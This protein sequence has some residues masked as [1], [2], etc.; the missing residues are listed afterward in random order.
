MPDDFEQLKKLVDSIHPLSPN[1]WQNFSG[2][3][4]PFFAK[5]KEII[6]VSGEKEKYLYLVID[7]VQR[8]YYF[9]DQNRE[10]TILFTYAP[11]F[12]GVLDSLMLQQPSKYFY[13][14]LTPSSFLRVSFVDLQNLMLASADTERM[15]RIGITAALSGVLERLVELQCFSSEE[16]FRKLLRRSPHIL[17]LVPHKYLANYLGIDPTNFSKLINKIRI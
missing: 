16:K 2:A 3:W 1:D 7:G 14:T 13:E 10:A 15:I 17:Q 8:I 6:T 11:S 9:D 5:R 12:G 4:K